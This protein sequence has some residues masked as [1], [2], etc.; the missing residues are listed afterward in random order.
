MMV[1]LHHCTYDTVDSGFQKTV[2]QI[3]QKDGF[4]YRSEEPPGNVMERQSV[5][6]SSKGILLIRTP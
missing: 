5:K 6:L 3:F 1:K 4:F 2:F